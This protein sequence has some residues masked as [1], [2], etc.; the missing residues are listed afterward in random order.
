MVVVDGARMINK[1][2]DVIVTSVHQTTA[3]DDFGRWKSERISRAAFAICRRR[4]G[5]G[6][7]SGGQRAELTSRM[8][9]ARSFQNRVRWSARHVRFS[10]PDVP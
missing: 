4:R 9:P 5:R 3:A 7:K 8:E 6:P 10:G 2:V 1:S